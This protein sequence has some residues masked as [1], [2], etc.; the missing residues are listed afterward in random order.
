MREKMIKYIDC[1]YAKKLLRDEAYF[2]PYFRQE[3]YAI[4]VLNKMPVEDVA[5]VI[6]GKW[7][8]DEEDVKWGNSLIKRFCSNCKKTAYWDEEKYC[9]VLFKYCPNCGAKMDGE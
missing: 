2:N 9:F 3:Q 1:E 8:E 6:H 5:P 4:E 7:L